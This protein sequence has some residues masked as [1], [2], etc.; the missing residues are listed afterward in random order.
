[1]CQSPS[2]RYGVYRVSVLDD[3]GNVVQTYRD[4]TKFQFR[5]IGAVLTDKSGKT[6]DVDGNISVEPVK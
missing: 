5:I 6:F 4:I 3:N 1:M 2:R